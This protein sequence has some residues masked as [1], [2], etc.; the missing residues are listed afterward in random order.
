MNRIFAKLQ[1]HLQSEGIKTKIPA[2]TA[3]TFILMFLINDQINSW[4]H[5]RE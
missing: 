2:Q 5:H 3:G 4:Q 1:L